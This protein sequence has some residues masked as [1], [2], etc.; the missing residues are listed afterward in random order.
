MAPLI[1]LLCGLS[2]LGCAALLILTYRKNRTRFL[3]FSSMCF[4]GLAL[5]N[6][7]LIVDLVLLPT[8]VSLL[9]ERQ[10]ISLVSVLALIWGFIWDTK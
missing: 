5:S 8:Q 2:S 1:Y 7:V 3:L 10:V 9:E 4:V 6:M